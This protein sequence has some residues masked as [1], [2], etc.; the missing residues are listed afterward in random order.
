MIPYDVVWSAYYEH[1]RNFNS[2]PLSAAYMCQWIGSALVQ[3]MACCLFSA[4]SL[5]KP[6]LVIVDWTLRNKLQWNFNQYTKL[7]I[8]ENAS[9]NIV[10]EMASRGRWVNQVTTCDNEIQLYHDMENNSFYLSHLSDL[11]INQGSDLS[12][13]SHF[14]SLTLTLVVLRLE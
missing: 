6:M 12:S 11:Y 7:F 10:C 3:I 4:K 8:H 5:S 13:I 1:F 14:K 2:S 9:E